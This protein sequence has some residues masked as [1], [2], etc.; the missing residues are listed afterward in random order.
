MT[1]KE[2][3]LSFL[4][5]N[6][7]LDKLDENGHKK[8]LEGLGDVVEKITKSIGVKPCNSCKERRDKLN[9]KFPFKMRAGEKFKRGLQSLASE[10]EITNGV[11]VEVGSFK[12]ES[13][14]IFANSGKFET[15][16]CVDNWSKNFKAVGNPD[17]SEVER[18]FDK[19]TSKYPSIKKVKMTSAEGSKILDM[20]D[21]VYIDA[22]HDY[23]SVKQDIELWL[24]KVKQGGYIA[25]HDYSD[26]FKGV[27]K[28]VD[29]RFKNVKIYED[30]SWIVKV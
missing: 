23:D 27:I 25:G 22:L 21:L 5:R 18:T 16:Y 26:E 7:L 8:K 30:T 6:G 9:D 13:A 11:M 28:A 2:R 15:I 20:V 29:E 1:H 19:E 4:E 24:P 10:L 3:M 12:G 17:M 14:I